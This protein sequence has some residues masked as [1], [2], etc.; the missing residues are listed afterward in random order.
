MRLWPFRTK[1]R[2][3]PPSALSRDA[4]AGWRRDG[5]L[6]LQK[7]FDDATVDELNDLIK[8]LLNP[9][10]QSIEW[11]DRIVIDVL[12]GSHS[13]RRCLL[14][15]APSEALQVP[16]KI[17]DLYLESNVARGL[18]LHPRL[19][20]IITELLDGAPAIRNSLNFIQGSQQGVHAD[21]WY[22][23]PLVKDKLI[24]SSICLEDVHPDAGALFYYPGSQLI[25]AYV[26]SHGGIRAVADE[27]PAC[28]RYIEGEI[29]RR[30]LKPETFLGQNGDV[31]LWS[32]QILH[33][34]M[35]INN[36]ALTRRTLVTHYWRAKDIPLQVEQYAPGAFYYKR[37]HQPVPAA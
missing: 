5:Y 12:A 26:F 20:P 3:P 16:M 14:R 32:A 2:T 33:G 13:G 8:Q 18:A 28:L 19:V 27:M 31:F 6:V 21:T 7:F 15:D 4:V 23:P 30:G 1:D 24:V 34:G 36:H 35:P 37:A 9:E 11:A 17:N 22:M 25:A 10:R 29:S